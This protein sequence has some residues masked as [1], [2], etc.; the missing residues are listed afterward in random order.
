M[1][2]DYSGDGHVICW[3]LLGVGIIP[4]SNIFVNM[5]KVFPIVLLSLQLLISCTYGAAFP[6]STSVS[7]NTAEPTS[8]NTLIPPI[9]TPSPTI[10]VKQWELVWQDEFNGQVLDTT[11]WEAVDNCDDQ[12]NNEQQCYMASAVGVREGSLVI[13]ALE[14]ANGGFAYTA[15]AVKT[16]DRFIQAY[17]RFEFR[18]KL[19]LGGDGIWPALWLYPL[20]QWPPEI[21]VL[22]AIDDQMGDI[23]MNYRWGTV[24]DPQHQQGITR[25][26]N[27]DDW[28]V[29]AVEWESAEIRWYVDDQLVYTYAESNI[30]DIPMQL[31]MNIALGGDWPKP[32]SEATVF[33]QYMYVDYVRVYK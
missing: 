5:I 21:D 32:V 10:E 1:A 22:E 12:R 25:V 31:H 17:G 2:G 7:T 24:Q 13:A 19:P 29:Y 6:T 8:T 3:D 28:H 15:G 33:P 16:G 27:P 18:A 26:Q 14:E 11:K 9:C 30:T 4:D 20:D 23:Y